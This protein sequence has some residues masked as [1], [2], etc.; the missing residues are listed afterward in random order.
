MVNQIQLFYKEEKL[1]C[2][3][4]L[5]NLQTKEIAQKLEIS[6]SLV[7]QLLNYKH[8]K[9]R[10]IHLYALQ[11]AYNI[12]LE[13]F[14]NEEIKTKA[15]I[16]KLLQQSKHTKSC[17]IFAKNH[18]IIES[19]KGI[20]YLYSYSSNSNLTDVWATKT[21][22]YDDFRV[23]DEF[24]NK[25]K[26]KIG[27][28]QSIILKESFNS[29]NLTSIVFNNH[30]VVYNIFPFSRISKSNHLNQELFNFGFFSKNKL[31]EDQAK[32]ILGERKEL[33]VQINH[34]FV[35]RISEFI[36]VRKMEV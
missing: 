6:S 4:K 15:D 18:D 3:V 13:I 21:E 35:E 2:V 12:P 24:N 26:I 36:E 5:L 14:D 32:Y 20:W 10:R 19:L 1:A 30:Q 33:Q 28:N 22:F 31:D 11:C 7:S 9:L 16:S 29:K 34:T 8:N 23:V 27:K 25:G 17:S